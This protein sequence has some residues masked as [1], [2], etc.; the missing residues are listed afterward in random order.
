MSLLLMLSSRM[1]TLRMVLSLTSALVI[2]TAAVTFPPTL[3]ASAPT[4]TTIAGDGVRIQRLIKA[5]YSERRQRVPSGIVREEGATGAAIRRALTESF[6]QR[7]RQ[8]KERPRVDPGDRRG[9]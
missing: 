3:S 5:S 1:S 4:A 2:S 8:R 9:A 6:G 7:A